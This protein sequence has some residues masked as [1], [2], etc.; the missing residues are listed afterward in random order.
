MAASPSIGKSLL[1]RTLYNILNE[2]SVENFDTAAIV[3]FL[4]P[5]IFIPYLNTKNYAKTCDHGD[6]FGHYSPVFDKGE[7]RIRLGGGSGHVMIILL[8]GCTL[9]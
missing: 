6:I 4:V 7:I 1:T 8:A 5:F 2:R 3:L 9:C